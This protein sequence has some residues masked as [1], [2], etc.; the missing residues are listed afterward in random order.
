MSTTEVDRRAH[1]HAADVAAI[2]GISPYASEWSKWAEKVGLYTPEHSDEMLERFEIGKDAEGFLADVFQRHHPEFR[3][4][5]QQAVLTNERW[6]WL[7]GHADAF[8]F[9]ALADAGPHHAVA[10]WEAK[11][12]N[13]FTPWTEIPAHYQCQAQ[14]YMMLSGYQ[15][16]WFTVGFAGWKVRHY[17]VEANAEDQALIAERTEAFWQLVQTRV[18]PETDGTQ[19]TWD[20]IQS[21][22]GHNPDAEDSLTA[23]SDMVTWVDQLR[24]WRSEQKAA[25]E[26]VAGLESKIK[27]RMQDYAE[28][29]GPDGS[30]LVT[31]KPSTSRRVDLDS[32]RAEHPEIVETYT[33]ETTTRRFLVKTPKEDN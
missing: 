19:A 3:V 10:G 2:L 14:T 9:D 22:Y 31:W 21:A 17:C 6:P 15:R 11:T 29:V 7:V 13:D 25:G 27:A 18:P 26:H 20:A 5:A 1:V 12:D 33:T 30:R 8:L 16:W 4:G 28:L 32:L 23:D 24:F